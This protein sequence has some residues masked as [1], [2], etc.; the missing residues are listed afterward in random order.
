MLDWKRSWS[1]LRAF[2][3]K[4]P[5]NPGAARPHARERPLGRAQWPDVEVVDSIHA[6]QRG[7]RQLDLVT[8]IPFGTPASALRPTPSSRPDAAPQDDDSDGEA[9]R[10]I[11]RLLPR[12]P[13]D[14][15]GDTTAI[16]TSAS[17]SMCR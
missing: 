10:R 1:R 9:H 3:S 6:V 5:D 17:A 8:S 14:E 7:K 13:D 11:H 2:S 4:S 16:E 12:P 15:T